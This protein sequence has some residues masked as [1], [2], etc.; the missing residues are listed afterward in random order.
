MNVNLKSDKGSE[1]ELKLENLNNKLS[2]HAINCNGI[3]KRN[4]NRLLTLEEIKENKFFTFCDN[5]DEVINELTEINKS[6]LIE[7]NNKV[8]LK[9]PINSKKIKEFIISINELDKSEDM[10][11][12]ELYSIINEIKAENNN[13]KLKVQ[14]LEENYNKVLNDIIY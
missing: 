4:F 3:P 7:E 12:K 6:I 5:I 14:T 13:L 1:F 8:I 9:I 11:F 10:K 2:I